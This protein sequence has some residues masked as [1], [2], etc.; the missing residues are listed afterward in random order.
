VLADRYRRIEEEQFRLK[1]FSGFRN[2]QGV[3]KMRYVVRLRS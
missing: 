1:N 3:A 2:R